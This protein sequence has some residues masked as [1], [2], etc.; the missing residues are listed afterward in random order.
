VAGLQDIINYATSLQI[1]RRRIVGIQYT[2]NQIARVGET[3]GRNP[4]KFSVKV[5]RPIQYSV[6]RALTE[7]LDR[8][9]RSLPQTISFSGNPKL[10][11]MWAYQGKMT[12]AQINAITISSFNGN[13]LIITNLGSVALGTVMFEPGDVLQVAG[14]AYPF[15][16]TAQVVRTSA[17]NQTLVVHRGNFISD[18][19]AGLGIVVGN[20][21]NF[22]MLCT[23]M[24]TYTIIRGGINGLVQFDSSFELFEYT[25]LE[26]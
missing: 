6:A 23:N 24:P 14:Q 8:L 21:V 13:N 19:V 11:W 7:E 12:T 1:S 16:V 3:P 22:Y 10:N 4:W 5:D 26:V 17:A 20:G 9:D 15:T 2:R 18:S 25:G